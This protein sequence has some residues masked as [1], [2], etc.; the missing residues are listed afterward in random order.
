MMIRGDQLVVASS[1]FA[2]NTLREAVEFARKHPG[3]VNY[4]SFGNGSQPHLLFSLIAEREKVSLTHIPYSGITPNLTALAAGDVQL[5]SGS[6]AV[7]A[8][9]V[10]S[11]KV[12]PLAIAGDA[13][14]P[15]YPKV[16]TTT[17]QGFPYANVS[18]WY[19]LFAP[20]GTPAE[21]VSQAVLADQDFPAQQVTAKGLAVV[22]N[23][24]RQMRDAIAAEARATAAMITAAGVVA[25]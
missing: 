19:G 21:V 18:I 10:A 8:A 9:Y 12:K 3:T 25:E 5:G 24:G 13:P 23:D 16:S 1:A 11:G 15:Q 20:A 4:G 17:E 6:A 14:V 22:A 2:A 7:I